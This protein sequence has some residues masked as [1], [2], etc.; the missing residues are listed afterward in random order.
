MAPCEHKPK[1]RWLFDNRRSYVCRHCGVLIELVN[2]KAEMSIKWLVDILVVAIWFFGLYPALQGAS[3][4]LAVLSAIPLLLLGEVGKAL[5]R[6]RLRY[7]AVD[8][9]A[10][11]SPSEDEEDWTF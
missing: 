6:D 11:T 8:R 4:V 3:R 7:Q 5:L 9:P 1:R 10:S 2:P